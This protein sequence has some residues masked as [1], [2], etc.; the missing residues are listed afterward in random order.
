MV[1][2]ATTSSRTLTHTTF[3][4]LAR[5]MQ[6]HGSSLVWSCFVI[7][8]TA[9]QNTVLTF[10][11]LLRWPKI[12][13]LVNVLDQHKHDSI[14]NFNTIRVFRLLREGVLSRSRPRGTF[15]WAVG[16]NL[17]QQLFN[18]QAFNFRIY[19]PYLPSNFLKSVHKKLSLVCFQCLPTLTWICKGWWCFICKKLSLT[20][21]IYKLQSF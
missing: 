5:V 10:S 1:F 8:K 19:L 15:S 17:H 13:T 12:K 2:E 18:D 21:I 7:V 16:K 11:D 3:Q 9:F 4:T 6:I 14:P 20:G